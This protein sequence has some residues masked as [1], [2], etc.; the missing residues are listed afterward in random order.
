MA[1]GGPLDGFAVGIKD[2]IDV[3]GLPTRCGSALTTAEPARADAT[4]VTRLRS[5]GAAI[6]GKTHCTE[7]ALNDPSP[8]RNPW[9]TSRTP[10]GSS[11]GS[12]VAVAAGMCRATVDTQTAG[13]VLRPA[14]YNGVVGFKPS[15]GWAP[16]YGVTPVAPTIDTI[17]IIA[18][19]VADAAAM[20]AAIADNPPALT[21][22]DSAQLRV[23]VLTG[24]YFGTAIAVALTNLAAVTGRLKAVGADVVELP[25]A[26]SLADA[27]AAHRVITF[28]ECAQHHRRRYAQQRQHYG[29]LAQELIDLGLTT[30]AHAYLDAQRARRHATAQL[31]GLFE[32]ADVL[33]MPVTPGPAPERTTTGDS[34]FQIPWT[35]CGFPALSLPAGLDPDHPLPLAIQLVGPPHHDHQLLAAGLWCENTIGTLP[36]PPTP[37]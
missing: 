5:A 8:T 20:A 18:R 10:G 24:S 9:D 1:A 15:S 19:T 21:P 6:V 29:P 17:G 27:Y 22:A 28:A 26:A 34:A 13:D 7:W 4:V 16:L 32:H 36:A 25:A 11:A 23:G 33:A 2:I 3:A 37:T 31:A 30:L 35:L 12:A 14:A